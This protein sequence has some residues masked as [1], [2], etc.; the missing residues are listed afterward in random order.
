M[1]EYTEK[2][3]HCNRESKISKL[4][5]DNHMNSFHNSRLQCLKH[6]Y[7]ECVNIIRKYL[8]P[9]TESDQSFL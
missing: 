8:L 5:G 2:K 3:R 6:F 7:L 9:K 1:D 4:G